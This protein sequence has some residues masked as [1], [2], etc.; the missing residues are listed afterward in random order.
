MSKLE[1]VNYCFPHKKRKRKKTF[2]FFWIMRGEDVERNLG[3][4]KLG[5]KTTLVERDMVENTYRD[6]EKFF[7]R[8]LQHKIL[9]FSHILFFTFIF[10]L[11]N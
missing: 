2:F 4:W 1:F 7:K 6:G 8:I 5:R 3:K 10:F 11:K 9:L